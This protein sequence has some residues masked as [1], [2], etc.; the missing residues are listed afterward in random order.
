[1][2]KIIRYIN[3]FKKYFLIGLI[4]IMI[5]L[6]FIINNVPDKKVISNNDEIIEYDN[7]YV[8][9]LKGEVVNPN[10]YYF[11][12][13]MYLFEVIENAGG[14]TSFASLEGINLIEKI[15]CDCEIVIN[16]EN[17]SKVRNIEIIDYC[18]SLSFSYLYIENTMCIYK[19]GKEKSFEEIFWLLGLDNQIYNINL[20]ECI[21]E[22]RMLSEKGTLLNINKASFNE[23]K[24]LNILSD[25]VINNIL[26]Y[27]KENKRINDFEELNSI[28]GI[29][30]KTISKLM[31]LIC[32][33]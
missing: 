16:K 20:K 11:N 19:F 3:E 6:G 9:D 18:N 24:E 33:N 25:T 21:K 31:N 32:F 15:N 13:E 29:G 30:D 17:N 12:K 8:V 27:I 7:S 4:V 10:K 26:L 5:V 23:L 14:F 1:M 2:K 28:K 22:D